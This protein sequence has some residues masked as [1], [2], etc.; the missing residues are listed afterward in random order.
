[1]KQ[2]IRKAIDSTVFEL[3]EGRQMYSASPAA[4]ISLNKGVLSLT[5]DAEAA[6]RMTVD[7]GSTANQLCVNVGNS[8]DVVSSAGITQIKVT[9]GNGNDFVYVNPNIKI[10]CLVN[11]GNGN[12]I[13]RTGAGNDTIVTGNGNDLIYGKAGNNSITTGNGNDTLLGDVGNDTLVAGNGNDELISGG[14]SNVL[15]V[16]TGADSL[17]V[18]LKTDKLSVAGHGITLSGLKNGYLYTRAGSLTSGPNASTTT[19]TTAATNTSSSTAT[20]KTTTTSTSTTT[21]TTAKTGTGTGSGSGTSGTTTTPVVT[22]PVAPAKPAA[23]T[24]VA[25]TNADAPVARINTLAGTRMTGMVVNVDA[26]QSTLTEGTDIQA[27]FAWDFGDPAGTQNT[28][29]GFNAAHVYDTAGT[30]TIKL[31]VTNVDG[32]SST[33]TETVTIA[34]SNRNIIYVDP[35]TGSDTNNG[36]QSSPLKTIQA[37]FNALQNNSEILLMA[38][39]TYNVPGSLEMWK[40]NVIIGRYGT[41]TDPMLNRISGNGT[42]TICTGGETNGFT[43]QNIQFNSPYGVAADAVANKVGVSGLYLYGQNITVRNCTF[44]NIDDAVNEIGSPTGV[45]IQ[46]NSAP[47]TTGLRG[48][49]V[50][51]QGTEQVIDDNFAANSTREHI[52]RLVSLTEVT[53][54]NN[55]FTNLDRSSV[56]GNDLSK[57]CIE[58]HRGAYEWIADNS[59]TDGDIRIGPLGLWGESPTS[60][61]DNAVIEDNQLTDTMIYVMAGAHNAMIDGNVI[62]NTTGQAI[63]IDGEDSSGRISSNITIV[64]NTATT[65]GTSGNFLM[66][67]GWATGITLTNNLWVA[68]NIKLGSNGTAPVYVNYA[69]L[70]GFTLI[71]DNVWPDPV[72]AGTWAQGGI[73]FVGSSWASSGYQTPA[74]WNA[75]PAVEADTFENVTLD[76][77]YQITAA[78]QVAGAPMK[79]AA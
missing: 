75:Q 53:I 22:T 60:S 76:G 62:N 54:E 17:S 16:G 77:S 74:E 65:T 64:N 48:Y 31:T 20:T 14:G 36:S 70:G 27:Q 34:A 33:A 32:C 6:T 10:P 79:M 50:W 28:M 63:V 44:L 8:W 73:N 1:M 5:G 42:S 61:T 71:G 66:V 13:V 25:P 39:Q 59:V 67:D 19:T 56:D 45:L 35:A 23:P 11:L 78:S 4:P 12:D 43:I 55:T 46:G 18:S 26:L 40:N 37:A 21:T 58:V 47:L 29:T 24:P 72:S 30:Y 41:G 38:G 68:P 49:M 51:G 69:S 7:Y 2:S 9:A 15:G 3:L 52:L 57:G